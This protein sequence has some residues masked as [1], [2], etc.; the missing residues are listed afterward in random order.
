MKTAA[1]MISEQQA[2]AKGAEEKQRAVLNTRMDQVIDPSIDVSGP[3]SATHRLSSRFL[4][5]RQSKKGRHLARPD[6][7]EINSSTK[8]VFSETLSQILYPKTTV[9]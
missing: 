3:E 8:H 5:W 1:Q 4:S 7:R 6:V 9:A 2:G